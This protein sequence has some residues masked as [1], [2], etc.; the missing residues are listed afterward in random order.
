MTWI[1]E[2]WEAVAGLISGI[3]VTAGVSVVIIA[4]A[5]KVART[6]G[7]MAFTFADRLEKG[8]AVD[9]SAKE[10][11]N[12]IKLEEMQLSLT[13]PLVAEGIKRLAQ[14]LDVKEPNPPRWRSFLGIIGR[15]LLGAVAAKLGG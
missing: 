3:M 2:H 4:K 9:A 14:K 13:K 12:S 1:V 5:A 15:I 6:F 11:K 10:V 8:H 7:E